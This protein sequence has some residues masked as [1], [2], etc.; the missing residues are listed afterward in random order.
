MSAGQWFW[1]ELMT[2]DMDKA[3][4][5]YSALLG[6][7]TQVWEE[8]ESYILWKYDEDMRGGMMKMDGPHFEGTPSHWLTYIQVDDIDA[9]H[10]KVGEL[11]GEALTPIQD[12]ASI[13]RF[14]VVSDPTGARFGLIQPAAQS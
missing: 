2:R 7:S 6:W 9:A 14:F 12:V 3:K 5:F 11:G 10:K 8:D 1:H 4:G 13:G